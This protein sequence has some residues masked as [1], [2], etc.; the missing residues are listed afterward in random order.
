[1]SSTINGLRIVSWNVRGVGNATKVN[2]VMAHLQQL[3]GDVFFLQETHLC[4][5]E[6]RRLKRNWIGNIYHSKFNAKA[7][8]TA[9]L[10]RNNILFEQH[11]VIADPDGRFTFVSGN[12]QGSLVILASVYGPNWDDDSFIAKLFSSLPN[13]ENYH[14]IIGGDFNLVQD[15]LLD[16]SSTKACSLNKS[17]KTLEFF[18]TQ[19]GIVDP[20]RHANPTTKAFSFFSHPHRTYTRIDFFLVDIRFLC[21]ISHCQY[22]AIAISDHS[23]VSFDVV[24]A[25][26]SRPIKHWR[27][28]SSLLIRDDYTHFLRSQF[29]LFLELNDSTEVSR[30][31]LWETSKAYMRG[32]L[33]GFVSNL[34]KKELT[35][36]SSLLNKIKDLDGRYASNPDPNLYTERVKVQASLNLTTTATAMVQL[37]KTKQRFFESGDKAGKL[38]AYQARAEATSKLIPKVKSAA[39]DIISDPEGINEVFVSFYSNLYTSSS[40][41]LSE[42]TLQNIQFPRID[43]DLT[44]GLGGPITVVEVQDAIKSLNTGKSPGPDGYSAEYYKVNSDLM[45]P[46]LKDMYNEAFSKCQL[47]KTLSEATICL[48]LKKDKDPLLCSSYRPI[49]LLN[50]DFKILSKIL[51]LRLQRA[52][53]QIIAFDQTGFM[54]G[55]HSYDNSRR[56][57]NIIHTS[58]NS[59][60]EVVASLDAEKAFDRV[61]WSFLYEVMDRFGLGADFILWV[62]LLY[63]SPSAC[64]R[65]NN[66]LSLPFPLERGTRQGCPLSPLLFAI[67]IEPLAIWL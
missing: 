21:K 26:P 22:H 67:A 27:F 25:T 39:G 60:P 8:G 34:K 55:R 63:S 66:N 31:V 10:I 32:Q 16:R 40:P 45:A 57:L 2:K 30:G 28:N 51:A 1:M 41:P 7:R 24:L 61:E 42:E 58:C 47:P 54:A 44:K 50:I 29:S 3:K 64:I 48:I 13:L 49:S 43:R 35:Y 52:L 19:L 33:I 37:I 5:R 17:A 20:W 59:I 14:L 18:K 65:T 56:L 6:V 46:L 23:P 9:I 4:N 53:S 12:L 62:K 11:K 15:T 36:T 38:L